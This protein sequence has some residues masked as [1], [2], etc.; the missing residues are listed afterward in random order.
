MTDTQTLIEYSEEAHNIANHQCIPR[1]LGQPS[2]T[3]AY[4]SQYQ[5]G[6]FGLLTS[7]GIQQ[8]NFD[9][10]P[11][12]DTRH[13]QYPSFLTSTIFMPPHMP[14]ALGPLDPTHVSLSPKTPSVRALGS[15][16]EVPVV[17][18]QHGDATQQA[19]AEYPLHAAPVQGQCENEDLEAASATLT[20]PTALERDFA[21]N[22]APGAEVRLPHTTSCGPGQRGIIP[23]SPP[24][25]LKA[26][27]IEHDP[28]IPQ[29]HT[30]TTQGQPLCDAIKQPSYLLGNVDGVCAP[31][32]QSS[33]VDVCGA[34]LELL[35][36][37]RRVS[38][39]PPPSPT[40][41]RC[42]RPNCNRSFAKKRSLKYHLEIGWCAGAP[43]SETRATQAVLAQRGLSDENDLS[44]DQAREVQDEVQR[45]LRPF[46]CNVDGCTHRYKGMSGLCYHYRRSGQHGLNG[47]RL[48][49]SG[50]H[51]CLQN[52]TGR[53]L[54]ATQTAA[55][56][57]LAIFDDERDVSASVSGALE[58]PPVPGV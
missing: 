1:Q 20:A 23:P 25:S 27:S 40:S 33:S 45:R 19:Y 22:N 10:A 56:A 5:P 21:H 3:A 32:L 54:H 24:V 14:E 37:P 36:I 11:E 44:K 2:Y 48:L 17:A 57:E 4:Y 47:L 28:A 50:Q 35:A 13:Y 34:S 6:L 46:A 8:Q 26:T 51:E 18:L 9:P 53:A 49:A 58:E 52:R 38:P 42:H 7:P 12:M 41:F 31:S 16:F 15:T 29:A 30:L 43:S 55:T 39:P